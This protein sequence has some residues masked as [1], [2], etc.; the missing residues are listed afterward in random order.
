MLHAGAGH[1]VNAV[2]DQTVVMQQ[3]ALREAGGPR[4]ILNLCRISGPGIAQFAD[5]LAREQSVMVGQQDAMDDRGNL[6]AH[7]VGDLL[8]WISAKI[9]DMING[10][11]P[12]LLENIFQFAFL[13]GRIDRDQRNAGEAAGQFEQHPFRQVVGVNRDARAFGMAAGKGAGK[14]LA[15]RQQP[16]I[17]PAAGDCSFIGELVESHLVGGG[18]NRLAQHVANRHRGRLWSALRRKMGFC[19]ID[20]VHGISLLG[21]MLVSGFGHVQHD[22]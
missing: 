16:G 11:R 13:I 9:G 10:F 20:A 21:S 15:V 12:R 18:R 14:P 17:G 2:A 1:G 8:H 3:R 6:V 19:Q 4:S 22:R 5:M 7:L